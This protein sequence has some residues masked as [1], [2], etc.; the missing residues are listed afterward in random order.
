MPD[1]THVYYLFGIV[2]LKGLSLFAVNFHE[3][4]KL[5][6]FLSVGQYDT[7]VSFDNFQ[8]ACFAHGGIIVEKRSVLR[9]IRL[10][11]FTEASFQCFALL[12][13]QSDD[14]M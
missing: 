11:I 1:V 8:V 3:F 13:S 5:L 4:G 2:L 9:S 10:S 14:S 12:F 7:Y 6:A